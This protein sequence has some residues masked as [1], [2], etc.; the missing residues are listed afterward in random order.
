MDNRESL[1]QTGARPLIRLGGVVVIIVS[2]GAVCM[3]VGGPLLR[4][5]NR[6]A[7]GTP[8]PVDWM[9]FAAVL[10]AI[11]GFLTVI[12]SIVKPALDARHEERL[13]EIRE[14]GGQAAGFFPSDPHP[15]D[16]P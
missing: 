12:W 15:G 11:G 5:L 16:S 10:G 3:L 6:W 9:G 13:H 1:L 7:D 2:L 8:P 4:A 14:G